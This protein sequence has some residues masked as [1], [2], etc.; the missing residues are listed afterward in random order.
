MITRTADNREGAAV[1]RSSP[2]SLELVQEHRNP[3]ALSK[4]KYRYKKQ[5]FNIYSWFIIIIFLMSVI[6]LIQLSLI[7]QFLYS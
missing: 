3:Q 1:G 2:P 6:D 4:A 7:V 5:R